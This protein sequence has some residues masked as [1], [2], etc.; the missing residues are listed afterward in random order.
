MTIQLPLFGFPCAAGSV[1]RGLAEEG[2]VLD[3]EGFM[4]ASSLG[5]E[6]VAR[7]VVDEGTAELTS[8]HS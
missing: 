7:R 1:H 2:F 5:I 6:V 8:G 3:R 4:V